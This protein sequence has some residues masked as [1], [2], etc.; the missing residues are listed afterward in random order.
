MKREKLLIVW[1]LQLRESIAKRI[2]SDS[3]ADS[4][5]KSE[6]KGMILDIAKYKRE[7]KKS[8]KPQN[9][10]TELGKHLFY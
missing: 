5:Q 8:T 4:K 9:F 2:S 10:W 1:F 6:K 3:N 7:I